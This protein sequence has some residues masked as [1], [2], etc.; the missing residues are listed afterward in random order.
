MLKF[1]INNDVIYINCKL[2]VRKYMFDNNTFDDI[3]KK[4]FDSLPDSLKDVEKD[5]QQKF[6]TVLQVTFDKLDLVTREEFEVQKK[7][8][9]K[10]RQKIEAI[11]EQLKN[12]N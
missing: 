11:E 5:L 4:L 6:K 12:N 3:S 1:V 2:L 10:T 8:L 7:V 9:A